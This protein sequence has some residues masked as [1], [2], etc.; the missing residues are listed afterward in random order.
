[1]NRS[2]ASDLAA[3]ILAI[4]IV[5]GLVF[6]LHT[7]PTGHGDSTPKPLSNPEQTE[8]T[9]LFIGDSYTGAS[10]LAEM[11]Y[12]CQ[13]ALRMHWLCDLAALPGTG[14]ISGGPANRFHVA[15]IGDSTSFDERV[16]RLAQR[17]APNI[18]VLDGGRND[19]FAPLDD[20]LEAMLGTVEDAHSTWPAAKI[21]FVR[22]RFLQRPGDDLGFDDDFLYRLK[23][24]PAMADVSVIDPLSSLDDATALVGKDGVHP[25]A[26]GNRRIAA[27]LVDSLTTHGLAT[28]R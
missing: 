5:A 16:H 14:Y 3:A 25:N 24:D 4:A 23:S 12:A 15:Y 18:I 1:M 13:A 6:A 9:A 27:A 19:I 26:D 20:V 2:R 10:M 8:P 17:S 7:D 22:P 11:S 28:A 21:V